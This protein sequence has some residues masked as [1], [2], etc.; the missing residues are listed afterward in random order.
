MACSEAT[1]LQDLFGAD[2][3]SVDLWQEAR[4][5]ADGSL[6]LK[7]AELAEGYGSRESARRSS[8]TPSGG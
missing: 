4:E 8:R 1:S 7:V 2:Y 3:V 5:R 6:P